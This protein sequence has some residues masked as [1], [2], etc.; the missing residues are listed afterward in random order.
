MRKNLGGG[1]KI[2][3]ARLRAYAEAVK[4]GTPSEEAY[5]LARKIS[6]KSLRKAG[7]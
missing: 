4:A 5:E 1:N 7:R 6:L 3:K 2:I